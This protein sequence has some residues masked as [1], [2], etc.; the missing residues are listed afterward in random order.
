MPA[1]IALIKGSVI[2]L[3]DVVVAGGIFLFMCFR[4]SAPAAPTTEESKGISEAKDTN[5]PASKVKERA[6]SVILPIQKLGR[7]LML[8]FAASSIDSGFTT[9][10]EQ[11]IMVSSTTLSEIC[12]LIHKPALAATVPCWG[13]SK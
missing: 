13:R 9:D 12:M 3:A 11:A 6:I 2:S 4:T 5:G 7:L 8:F 1:V 10:L